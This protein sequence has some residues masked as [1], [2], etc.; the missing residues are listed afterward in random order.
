MNIV[1]LLPVRNEAWVLRH[2]LACLSGFCDVILV[3]DQNSEDESRDI[4][5]QFPKVTMLE[6]TESLVCEQARWQLWDAARAFGGCNLFWCTD[7]DELVSPRLV[8]AVLDRR[9]SE[10]EPGTI[11]ECGYYHLWES[12]DRYR[13]DGSRYGPHGKPV[14]IVDDGRVDYDRSRRLPLHE[15]RVPVA[16]GAPLLRASD[17][18]VLHLQWLIAN[19]N[20]MKQAWYRCREWL[21]GEK[22]AA[23][24]NA[25]YSVTFPA[26]RART[27]PVPREWTADVTFP[28]SSVDQEP[29]WH[30]REIFDWFDQYG[31]EFFEPLE[32]WHVATLRREFARRAG[33]RAK[34]DRSYTAPWTTRATRFARRAASA[35]R[36]RLP[37]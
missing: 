5:R 30:Q 33:R 7:A 29:T 26:P 18:P 35:V 36:R 9:R 8:A 15:E 6:S 20:Q 23:A 25:F 31:V 10:L 17:V 28:D 12:P 22:S 24:I 34:P 4:C 37:V 27:T 1:A 13:D 19:S 16:P 2:S 32:I 14:A 3:N 11:L 21:N